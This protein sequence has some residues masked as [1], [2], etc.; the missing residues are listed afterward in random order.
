MADRIK[1]M[2]RR[3][4]MTKREYADAIAE[5]IDGEVK[6]VEKNNGIKLTGIQPK[7][8]Y[9]NRIA[10]VIY[11]DEMY[12]DEL[13]ID[14]AVE[15]VTERFDSAI[16]GVDFD[17]SITTDFNKAKEYL[18]LRL[19][20]AN[21]NY[22]VF[23][24]ASEYGFD[25]LIIVPVLD[26]VIPS[27]SIKFTKSLIESLGVTEDEIFD[28]A[29]EN[30]KADDYNL[31]GMSEVMVEM[32]G[33]EQAEM[34]G[35]IVN[36]EDE[37]MFVITSKEKAFGAFGVIA[38]KEKLEE[39]FPNGYIVLPSS[40]HEVIVVPNDD[41]IEALRLDNLINETNDTQVSQEEQL[42]NKAYRFVA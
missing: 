19:Y 20:N 33:R 24:S 9:E 34:M 25:D 42:G 35:V 13:S 11:I 1:E 32:I 17:P 31:K 37:K 39:M 3:K 10:P 23:R 15:I 26:N 28:A 16:K 38:L 12:N 21:N 40:V 29:M 18:K 41:S 22:E 5:R 8:P 6:E 27:G 36:P 30:I 14:D 2:G 7:Q 4:D